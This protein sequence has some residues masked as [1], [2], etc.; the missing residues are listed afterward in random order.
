MV[1]VP[2]LCWRRFAVAGVTATRLILMFFYAMY[3]CVEGVVLG[4]MRGHVDD[5]GDSSY[6]KRGLLVSGPCCLPGARSRSTR[7]KP[8]RFRHNP[9]PSRVNTSFF[10]PL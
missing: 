9:L 8:R 2:Q 5:A 10:L 3:V 1:D 4:V 7:K 6:V